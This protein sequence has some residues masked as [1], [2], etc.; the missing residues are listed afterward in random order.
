LTDKPLDPSQ[1]SLLDLPL[2]EASE[3]QQNETE[4]GP[5]EPSSPTPP[6]GVHQHDLF[7]DS[8]PASGPRAVPALETGDTEEVPQIDRLKAS[9]LDLAAHVVVLGVLALGVRTL[10]IRIDR[11]IFA[12]LAAALIAFSFLYTVPSLMIWGRTPGMT[13]GGVVA[14]SSDGMPIAAGQALRRWVGGWITWLTLGLAG[15]ARVSDRLS[16]TQTHLFETDDEDAVI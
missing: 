10:G 7:G 13:L 16:G 1:D 5:S 15:L 11:S 6:T 2:R 12:P 4:A 8:E 14:E 3:T 9:L